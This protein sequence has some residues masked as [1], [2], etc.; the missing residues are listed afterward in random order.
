MLCAR[1]REFWPR[2]ALGTTPHIYLVLVT[3]ESSKRI[4]RL[5]SHNE[6]Q[7]IA[8]PFELDDLLDTVSYVQK[9]L[10][11]E[12]KR[13]ISQQQ[14]PI[15]DPDSMILQGVEVS[16]K[17]D[18]SIYAHLLQAHYQLPLIPHRAQHHLTQKIKRSLDLMKHSEGL[19]YQ[20]H[21]AIAYAGLI[22]A[23]VFGVRMSKL[24]EGKTPWQAYDELLESRG[25]LP[26]FKS[27]D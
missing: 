6:I 19:D 24:R 11:D 16:P 10:L 20:K 25:E 1:R 15:S 22:T 12:E 17:V 18:L 8:K 4:E 2:D 21:R 14:T 26:E 9:R 13:A 23:L 7:L 27:L 5:C 3:G